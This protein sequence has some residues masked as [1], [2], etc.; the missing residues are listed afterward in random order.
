M[1]YLNLSQNKSFKQKINKCMSQ[2]FDGKTSA[3]MRKTLKYYNNCA[4]SLIMSYNNRKSLIFKLL[5]V[6]AYLFIDKYVCVD[7]LCLKIEAKFPL[8]HREFE[9]TSFNE[10]SGIGIQ[11][12]LFK[13]VPCCGY[14]QDKN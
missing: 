11:E 9:D 12:I 7:Y 6:V 1:S 8:L 13:I 5:V 2:K 10:L 4:I 14:I 3:H